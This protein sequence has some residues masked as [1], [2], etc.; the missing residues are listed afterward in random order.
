MFKVDDIIVCIDIEIN[1]AANDGGIS[2]ISGLKGLTIGKKYQVKSVNFHDTIHIMNDYNQI[3][4]YFGYRFITL[5]EDRRK[6]LE[7]I[8]NGQKEKRYSS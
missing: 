3:G 2:D 7:K 1:Y 5:T 6:K 8:R 4:N